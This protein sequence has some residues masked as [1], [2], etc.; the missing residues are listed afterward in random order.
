MYDGEGWAT[1]EGAI[2]RPLPAPW[3]DRH[4]CLRPPG[5]TTRGRQCR[6]G[7]LDAACP[8]RSPGSRDL[9][10]VGWPACF[11]FPCVVSHT[12]D[13]TPMQNPNHYQARVCNRVSNSGQS[14]H[15][16]HRTLGSARKIRLI[17]GM[18]YAEVRVGSWERRLSRAV[19]R[20]RS[21]KW[22]FRSCVD[23]KSSHGGFMDIK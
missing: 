12:C 9:I 11:A 15:S 21:A 22:G 13:Q 19:R 2:P 6:Q 8:G 18:G 17:L 5:L 20:P 1:R 23:C 16:L 3:T 10:A 7:R 4:V 14:N